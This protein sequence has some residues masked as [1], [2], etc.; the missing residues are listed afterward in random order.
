MHDEVSRPHF[1]HALELLG[2]RVEG[3]VRRLDGFG[4][5]ALAVLGVMVGLL[6][7]YESLFA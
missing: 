6:R 5:L 2:G 7:P 4:R 1:R 3:R